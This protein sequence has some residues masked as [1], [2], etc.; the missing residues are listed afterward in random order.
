MHKKSLKGKER[1]RG[2]TGDE[3]VTHLMAVSSERNPESSSSEGCLL[4]ALED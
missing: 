4:A 2:E 3:S 1:R